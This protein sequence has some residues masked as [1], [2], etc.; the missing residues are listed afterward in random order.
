M[1]DGHVQ[2]L[3][4]SAL[5]AATAVANTAVVI[6]LPAT[7]GKRWV[8]PS[9]IYSYSNLPGVVGGIT[10]FD[11]TNTLDWDEVEGSSKQRSFSPHYRG[12]VNTAVVITLKAGGDGVIGKL[13]IVPAPYLQG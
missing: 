12:E 11:G 6:T 3:P 2:S 10:M 1:G 7:E 5:G 4:T 13:N 8:V 9:L